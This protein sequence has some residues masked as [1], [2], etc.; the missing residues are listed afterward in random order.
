MERR[1]FSPETVE[2]LRRLGHSVE[3]ESPWSDAQ[4]VMIDPDTGERL[5]GGDARYAAQPIG[6]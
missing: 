2:R 5:G 3:L 4:A 6:Y 1:G